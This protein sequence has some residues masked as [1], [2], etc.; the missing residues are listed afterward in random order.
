M[1]ADI[2]KTE[3]SGGN[4]FVGCGDAY[5]HVCSYAVYAY[6]CCTLYSYGVMPDSYFQAKHHK[7]CQFCSC[8][9]H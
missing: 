2:G 6:V 4:S 8:L 5:T 3:L 1:C 7:D 9:W